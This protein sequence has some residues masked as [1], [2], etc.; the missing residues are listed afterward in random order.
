M[1][2]SCQNVMADKQAQGAI[3]TIIVPIYNTEKY[4]SRCIDSLIQQSLPDIQ[5]LLINDGSSDR[6]PRICDQY[7]ILDKRIQ[8]VHTDN[9]GVSSARNT[10]IKLTQTPFI[11]F[12]DSDDYVSPELCYVLV[13]TMTKDQSDMALCGF[14][15]IEDNKS[16]DMLLRSL[17]EL[18]Y[19]PFHHYLGE[20]Q[21]TL[22]T[23]FPF[24]RVY[25]AEIIKKNNITF[26]PNLKTGEDRVFNM[27]YFQ[28]TK[29]ISVSRLP[30]Y[31]YVRRE[32]STTFLRP[33]PKT[34]EIFKNI[35]V[36]LKDLTNASNDKYIASSLADHFLGEILDCF[37]QK[38]S[39][40]RKTDLK[41]YFKSVANYPEIKHACQHKSN[42]IKYRFIALA[43]GSE[44]LMF[45]R[46]CDLCNQLGQF[47]LKIFRRLRAVN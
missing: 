19:D 41:L 21:R 25:R 46:M 33:D 39:V 23:F 45:L 4:L 36:T 22:M 6:S 5:I 44:S 34:I 20:M 38:F 24:A 30:L 7:A 17:P 35:Y 13:K 29:K 47:A 10:G 16:S 40:D 43:I 2:I 27:T 3:L 18:M 9:Q 11:M 14:K 26:D 31:Y 28:H 15:V 1:Q 42:K 32:G 8:V 12:V 37:G